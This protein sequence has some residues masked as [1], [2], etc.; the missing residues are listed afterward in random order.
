MKGFS[1]ITIPRF[2]GSLK[3]PPLPTF[4]KEELEEEQTLLGKNLRKHMA[5]VFNKEIK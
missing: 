4:T 1:K 2:K 3:F 5:I